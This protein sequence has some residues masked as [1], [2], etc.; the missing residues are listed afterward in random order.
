MQKAAMPFIEVYGFVDLA[1]CPPEFLDLIVMSSESII[2]GIRGDYLTLRECL[3]RFERV[4]PRL[5]YHSYSAIGSIDAEGSR[6]DNLVLSYVQ[7][8]NR[9]YSS[10]YFKGV[11][12]AELRA[13]F[14]KSVGALD[15]SPFI[16]ISFDQDLSSFDYFFKPKHFNETSSK[17]CLVD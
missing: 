17:D 12:V 7:V 6:Y 10:R 13:L 3:A 11:T 16:L 2:E 8:R 15:P 9:N 5:S 1:E 14:A 4:D